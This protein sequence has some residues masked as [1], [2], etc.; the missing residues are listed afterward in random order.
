MP[1]LS[2]PAVLPQPSLYQVGYNDY[3]TIVTI[4]TIEES[5]TCAEILTVSQSD[6]YDHESG[7]STE[8]DDVTRTETDRL[9]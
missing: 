2:S 1:S 9:G 5:L 7:E 6:I 8:E 4:V 3:D